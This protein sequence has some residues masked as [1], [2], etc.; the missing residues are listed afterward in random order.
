MRPPHR[1][2]EGKPGGGGGLTRAHTGTSF[3]PR[4]MNRVLDFRCS[5]TIS[6]YSPAT[7]TLEP[8]QRQ[9][10][11]KG[12]MEDGVGGWG[13]HGTKVTNLYAT[14]PSRMKYRW[15]SVHTCVRTQ[16]VNYSTVHAADCVFMPTAWF[17]CTRRHVCVPAC[18]HA[19]SGKHFEAT[20]CSGF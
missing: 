19:S 13:A 2:T 17:G 10:T 15:A 12:V 7:P 18:A 6:V 11:K 1:S 14:A 4:E 8:G 3:P 16:W 9:L 20:L 5:P